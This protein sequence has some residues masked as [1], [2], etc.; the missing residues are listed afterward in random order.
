MASTRF[1]AK[2]E[3]CIKKVKAKGFSKVSAIKICQSRIKKK[4]I[5]AGK[6][7]KKSRNKN[8]RQRRK[9]QLKA[10]TKD[11]LNKKALDAEEEDQDEELVQEIVEELTGE[12]SEDD[13]E[14]KQLAKIMDNLSDEEK[15]EIAELVA[16]EFGDEITEKHMHLDSSHDFG[17]AT[18]FDELEEERDAREKTSK[19]RGV[20]WDAEDI[21]GNVIRNPLLKADEKTKKIS[22][23]AKDMEKRI[24]SVLG[25]TKE[26]EPIIDPSPK[27]AI[28]ILVKS[29]FKK[30]IARKADK[31]VSSFMI[32]KD[33]NGDL[34]WVGKVTNRWFDREGDILTNASHKEFIGFLDENPDMAPAFLPWHNVKAPF[35]HPVDSWMYKNGFM[36]FSGKLEEAEA[37]SLVQASETTKLGMSHGFFALNRENINKKNITKYRTF[38]VS[39]LPLHNAANPYTELKVIAKEANMERKEF[40]TNLLGEE[41]ATKFLQD[42]EETEK[43]LDKSGVKTK[44]VVT[45]PDEDAIMEKIGK[46]LGM[47]ELSKAFTAMTEEIKELREGSEMRDKV[48]KAMADQLNITEAEQTDQLAKMIEPKAASYAWLQRASQ[49]KD[50]LVDESDPEDEKLAKGAP[51]LDWLSKAAGTVPLDPTKAEIAELA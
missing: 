1:S 11:I 16:E 27:E 23:A 13:E 20:A 28:G 25:E 7:R 3:R 32:S 47:P 42:I 19:A 36:V 21:I 44:D 49:T 14:T 39:V 9:A 50:N 29:V 15:D 2:Q 24:N 6:K 46:S 43:D 10:L 22:Q 4:D 17:G 45:T 8:R 30:I 41:K 33:L 38:E 18:S 12:L 26:I 51:Q 31:V 37:K 40:L 5:M 34:R 35:T 48:I